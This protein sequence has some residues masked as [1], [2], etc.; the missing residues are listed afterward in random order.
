MSAQGSSS[1]ATILTNSFDLLLPVEGGILPALVF[2]FNT[3]SLA[4]R[5]MLI[6]PEA[7][8]LYLI[9]CLVSVTPVEPSVSLPRL[10]CA[11]SLLHQ[12][13]LELAE[14]AGAFCGLLQHVFLL[15]HVQI[16]LL[17]TRV[18]QL[19]VLEAMFFHLSHQ[20]LRCLQA[21]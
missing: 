16:W 1:F 7:G 6:N 20:G 2:G 21:L 9:L 11:V 4:Q 19:R 18:T 10:T 8:S 17:S 13:L 12:H 14:L 15:L 3:S 5:Q